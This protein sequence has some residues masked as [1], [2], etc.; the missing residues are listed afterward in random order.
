MAR[1]LELGPVPSGSL[2]R[3]GPL[4]LQRGVPDARGVAPVDPEGQA[5]PSQSC[6]PTGIDGGSAQG[7]AGQDRSG[8]QLALGCQRPSPTSGRLD[9]AVTPSRAAQRRTAG[10][11]QGPGRPSQVSVTNRAPTLIDGAPAAGIRGTP[12]PSAAANSRTTVGGAV[13]VQRLGSP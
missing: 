3:C 10:P 9:R 11:V 2:H 8:T 1:P 5:A 13:L 4:P 12:L 6:R 7:C